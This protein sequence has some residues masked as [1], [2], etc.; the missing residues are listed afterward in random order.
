MTRRDFIHAGLLLTLIVALLPKWLAEKLLREWEMHPEQ[1]RVTLGSFGAILKKLYPPGALE[2]LYRQES[3][4]ASEPRSV[5]TS[6]YGQLVWK[7]PVKPAGRKVS[8]RRMLAETR[9]TAV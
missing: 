5:D 2:L 8:R 7:K 9:R 4:D 1:M 6:K 3:N